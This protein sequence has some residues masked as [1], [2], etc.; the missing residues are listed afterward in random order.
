MIRLQIFVSI[1]MIAAVVPLVSIAQEAPYTGLETRQI[2]ALSPEQIAEYKQ[3]HGMG[4]ALAA[5]LNGFP[6]PKHVLELSNELGL[7]SEQ[8]RDVQDVYNTMHSA[9]VD[10][11]EQIVE[12]EAELDELF[13]GGDIDEQSLQSHLTELASLQGELRN[14]HL[15][16]HL[17]TKSLL[18]VDQVDSY[19]EMR[20]YQSQEHQHHPGNHGP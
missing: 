13:V 16:A 10:L 11:G 15:A 18:T 1:L 9:A 20:G 5:E 17:E 12:R 2:K 8:R 7:T 19:N 6:G 14:A 3:G 4:L